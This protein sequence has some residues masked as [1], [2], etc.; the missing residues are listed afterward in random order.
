MPARPNFL[1]IITDQHRADYLGCYGHPL[2]KTPN[3]DGIAARGAQFTRFYVANPICMP[4]RSTLMTGRMPS[5]HGVRHNGIELSLSAN[6]FVDLL[7]VS[8]YRTALI[9]KSHLQ[10]M[11]GRPAGL[12]R[13]PPADGHTPAPPSFAEALKPLDDGRY[14]QELPATWKP[15]PG[16]RVDTP[17]YGF[18]HVDL[19]TSHGDEVGGNYYH[20]LRSKRPDAGK[21]VGKENALPHD[22]VAPQAWRTAVPEDLYPTSY[23]A[24]KSL[25][26]LDRN[27][28]GDAPFFLMCSFP[29]P[30]HPFTPPGKYW[31]MYRPEDVKLPAS[32]RRANTAEPH[33]AW[34]HAQLEGGTAVRTTPAPYAVSEREARESIALTC[35]MIAMID[36]AVGRILAKLAAAGRARD[37]VVVFTAD[38]GDFLADHGLM[39]KGPIHLQG[40]IRV[41]FIWAEPQRKPRVTDALAGTLDIAGSILDRAGIEPYNGIQGK[42]ILPVVEGASDNGHDAVLVEEDGQRTYMGFDGPIR[43]R[44]LVTRRWRTTIYHGAD[45]GE[46]Y[47]L[48]SDPGELN[49]LWRDPGHAAV[50]AELME[51]MARKQMALVDRSPLPT[52]MA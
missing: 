37:T 2:L 34:L 19:C 33:I 9:G 1:F 21:L 41:P 38:H 51:L 35:G 43:C 13:T 15:D 25:E 11:E 36:D 50:R 44:T 31:G 39:L 46:L 20:W 5:L 26:W 40:L 4:N 16:Y 32:F 17:F 24:E 8:G 10:N 52:A 48:E 45:W 22:Y 18:G 27:A 14:G 3:I 42:S 23:I 12:R 30:H 49:N 29:D 7:R 47:D 6:T 28:D